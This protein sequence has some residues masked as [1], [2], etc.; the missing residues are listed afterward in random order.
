MQ[1][2]KPERYFHGNN[3]LVVSCLHR[4]IT[5]L[6]MIQRTRVYSSPQ[7]LTYSNS[8]LTRMF[9]MLTTMVASE[10]KKCFTSSAHF[11][12]SNKSGL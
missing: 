3:G 4:V 10:S 9:E 12:P 6:P 1:Y 2:P 11:H 7:I 8:V 5:M